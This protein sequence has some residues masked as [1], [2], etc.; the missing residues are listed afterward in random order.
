[1]PKLFAIFLFLFTCA[2]SSKGQAFQGGFAGGLVGSQVAGDKY[3]G[4]H[5]PGM[6]G[7]FWVRLYTNES[8]SFQTELSYF[9]K[10]SRHNPDEKKQDFLFYLMRL[11]YIEMP[12]LYQ[13]HFKSKMSIEVGPSVSF[14]LHNYEAIDDVEVVDG[15]FNLIN[16]SATVGVGYQLTENLTAN[17][18][19]VSSVSSIRHDKVVGA[20]HRIFDSGQYNDCIMLFLSYKF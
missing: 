20:V 10:G 14:L 17:F 6:Y 5:K 9:Q 7:A 18:R 13:Y 15:D 19:A 8:S 2:I 4:F 11:G 3:S 1:M 16:P 12:F